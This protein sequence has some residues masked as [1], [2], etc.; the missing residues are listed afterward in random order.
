M[1]RAARRV[2]I[3]AFLLVVPVAL[4]SATAQTTRSESQPYVAHWTTQCGVNDNVEQVF[5]RLWGEDPEKHVPGAP[6]FPDY[7]QV[8]ER[9]CFA[10]MPGD[11]TATLHVT[12]DVSPR[13][14]YWVGVGSRDGGWWTSALYCSD[15]DVTI[16]LPEGAT[17]LGV[18]VFPASAAGCTTTGDSP[19][20]RLVDGMTLATTGTVRATFS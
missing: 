3:V 19:V 16:D 12:D 4:S 20:E 5:L 14:G 2:V 13:V 1:F 15:A 18:T 6:A 7:P 11:T 10:V 8:D 9:V 17:R